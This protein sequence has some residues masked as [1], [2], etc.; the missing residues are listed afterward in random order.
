MALL[1]TTV[2]V[3]FMK[4]TKKGSSGRAT[5]KLDELA[6]Q[7]E[8]LRIAIFTVGELFVGVSKG[9]Q[10]KRERRAVETCLSRFEILPFERSTAEI[11]GAIVGA[12]EKLG[13]AISDMD[14]LIAS[15]ALEHAERLVTRNTKHFT[16]I[17]GLAVDGY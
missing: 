4:E 5:T 8:P 15:V 1:D 9:T 17:P 3:D 10:P 6:R 2:L 14:A 12:L 11:F 16:R 13:L 7:G